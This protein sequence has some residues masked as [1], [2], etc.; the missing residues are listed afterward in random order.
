MNKLDFLRSHLVDLPADVRADIANFPPEAQTAF[1]EDYNR[2]EKS[3]SLAYVFHLVA[4]LAYAYEGKWIKQILFWITFYGFGV[5][6]VV[7]LFRLPG[8]I[9]KTNKEIARKISRRIKV[10]LNPLAGVDNGGRIGRAT[11]ERAFDEL[12]VKP[13]LLEIAYDP[14]DL[15]IDNLK[16]GALLDYKLQTWEVSSE[17]Q[18]DWQ[19]GVTER[20]F[21]L[22]A[23]LK[24]LRLSF[25]NEHREKLCFIS[26]PINIHAIDPNL[27]LTILSTRQP[28]NILSFQGITYYRE[29]SLQGIL[30]GIS[31]SE[32][33]KKAMRWEFMDENRH[34]LLLIEIIGEKEFR[35]AIG[36]RVSELEFSEIL[37]GGEGQ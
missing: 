34:H 27:Q 22:K 31:P 21:T 33:G 23:D 17:R 16:A 36:Q 20:D 18:Y 24:E 29:Y 6:W 2:K 13:R 12:S 3:I 35:C 28:K 15:T 11:V 1:F 7:Q 8:S 37:P 32:A 10:M 14:T 25:H 4:G 19:S 26:K 5:W 30:F 9:K